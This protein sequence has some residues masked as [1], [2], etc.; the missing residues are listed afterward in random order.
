[1]LN[2]VKMAGPAQKEH[3]PIPVRVMPDTPE[4]TAKQVSCISVR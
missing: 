1:M 2:R 3:L 4:Q